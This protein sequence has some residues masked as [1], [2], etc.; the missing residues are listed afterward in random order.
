MPDFRILTF[1]PVR[2]EQFGSWGTP[3]GWRFYRHEMPLGMETGSEFD[4]IKLGL[5]LGRI[6]D[7]E[8]HEINCLAL[9]Q[10]SRKDAA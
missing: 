7:A 3:I 1:G 2:A 9:D 10:Y 5:I 8:W 6:P 4:A